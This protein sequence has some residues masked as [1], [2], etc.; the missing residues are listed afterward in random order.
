M[1]N[2]N[3]ARKIISIVFILILVFGWPASSFV[4]AQE[5]AEVTPTPIESGPTPPAETQ[6]TP[7][8]IDNSAVVVDEVSSTSDTGDNTIEVSP[9]PTPSELEANPVEE[10]ET[11]VPQETII[12][13]SDAVSFTEVEN[14]VNTTEVNSQVSDQ[15]LNILLDSTGD[16]DLTTMS[17]ETPPPAQT[18]ESAGV[19]EIANLASVSNEII[20]IANT[21]ENTAE[22]SGATTISTGDSYSIVTLLNKV[23]TIII[24]S[25]LHLVTINIFGDMKGNIILPDFA[26]EDATACC[27][28]FIVIENNAGV[29][30]IIDSSAITGENTAVVGDSGNIETGSAQS[31]VNVFNLVNMNLIGV[32]FQRLYINNAGQW[33]GNFLG[34]GNFGFSEGG[35]S[36]TFE[37]VSSGGTGGCAGCGVGGAD[38]ENKALV[39]N[40]ITSLAN[41]GGNSATGSNV[42]IKTGNAYSSV[43]AANLVNTSII[44]SWGFIG[45]INIFGTLEGDIGGA[46]KFIVPTPTPEPAQEVT[47][48][49]DWVREQG[50]LLSVSHR[51]N[52]GEYVL[53]GDTVTFFVN[54]KNPGSGIV[55]D[56]K[57]TIALIKDGIVAGGGL[58]NLGDI[59]PLKSVRLSTG[60]V[61]S[62]KAPLGEYLVRVTASGLVGPGDTEISAFSD[63]KFLIGGFSRRSPIVAG[64]SRE[65]GASGFPSEPQVLGSVAPLR[66][67]ERIML[68]VFAALLTIYLSGRGYQRRREIGAYIYRNRKFLVPAATVLRSLL[69]KM[70]SLL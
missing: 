60:L 40:N 16:I 15:T 22:G 56:T 9:T 28:A 51:H 29:F 18:S 49:S 25:T 19:L 46:S 67:K 57:L 21:G 7:A 1:P 30:N 61:L 59:N 41:T 63:S 17:L 26:L 39:T 66:N 47:A 44:N 4:L 35:Q 65:V 45:F 5:V 8:V 52:V 13:T 2:M 12:D 68:L 42:Q 58:F 43:L 27:S 20:S 48:S 55:Y 6:E 24:D 10:E 31:I 3:K 33:T 50:G 54:V 69:F 64:L 62:K 34:W 38:I 11:S 23:N 36:L 32:I 14:N 53:P 70:G 37:S